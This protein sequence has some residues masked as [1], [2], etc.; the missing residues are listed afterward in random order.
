MG[1]NEESKGFLE[2]HLRGGGGTQ[3]A[4][5]YVEQTVQIPC[6]ETETGEPRYLSHDSKGILL[7]TNKGGKR[8]S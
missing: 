4:T 2:V 7:R 3:S 5:K 8:Q 1:E 6:A